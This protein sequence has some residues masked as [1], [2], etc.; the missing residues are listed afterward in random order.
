MSY[1]SDLKPC[2]R[3]RSCYLSMLPESVVDRRPRSS[4]VLPSSRPLSLIS[5]N[6]RKCTLRAY[7]N[8]QNFMN[9]P[10]SSNQSQSYG[11]LKK[12]VFCQIRYFPDSSVDRYPRSRRLLSLSSRLLSHKT[13]KI[14]NY[15]IRATQNVLRTSKIYTIGPIVAKLWCF[16]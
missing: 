5:T 13:I 15:M 2:V 10:N 14:T 8:I 9:R 11:D 16:L 1:H 12:V 7:Q 3:L 4:Y 6:I